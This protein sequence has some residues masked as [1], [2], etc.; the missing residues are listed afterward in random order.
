M[1]LD[2]DDLNPAERS[3]RLRRKRTGEGKAH[4]QKR[5]PSHRRSGTR[6]KAAAC[7]MIGAASVP[8]HCS[9]SEQ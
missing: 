2:G 7:G 6:A 9:S 5:Q 8:S 4:E 3:C 1:K